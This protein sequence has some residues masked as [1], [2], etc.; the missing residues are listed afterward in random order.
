MSVF[1]ISSPSR[2]VTGSCNVLLNDTVGLCEIVCLV[3]HKAPSY[4]GNSAIYMLDE[5]FHLQTGSATYCII[6]YVTILNRCWAHLW[7]RGRCCGRR[8]MR[9]HKGMLGKESSRGT[10]A[11]CGPPA[12]HKATGELQ[13]ERERINSWFYV[14]FVHSDCIVHVCVFTFQQLGDTEVHE[15]AEDGG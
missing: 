10:A 3:F 13:V 6:F 11:D 14:S 9:Q 7:R 4:G 12:S 15:E 2:D 1:L 5:T 8:T